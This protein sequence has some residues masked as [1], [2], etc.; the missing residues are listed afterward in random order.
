LL[1]SNRYQSPGSPVSSYHKLEQTNMNTLTDST[2]PVHFGVDVAKAE[3][4]LDLLGHT[5]RFTNDPKGIASLLKSVSKSAAHPYIVCEATGGY[6]RNLAKAALLQ[7]VL[8]SVVQPQRVREYANSQGQFAKSDP[9]DAA[10]LTQFGA[11]NKK[12]KPLTAKDSGRQKIDE[13]LRARSELIDA[14]Q[15]ESNRAEHRSGTVLEQVHKKLDAV[16]KE[17][18]RKLDKAIDAMVAGDE[19][20]S[21]AD[22]MLREVSGV[23]P[24]TSRTLL[25]F[26]PELGR[27][28]RGTIAALVGLA[29]FDKDSGKRT[30]KRYIRGGRSQIR[31]VLHMAAVS[32]TRSNDVLKKFYAELRS[33]GKEFKV[34]IVATARKLLIYLNSLMAKFLQN[35]VAE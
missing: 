19:N 34:A 9:L 8:I 33:N 20:L 28:G 4:V 22:A 14:R 11:V 10:L 30:G 27:V 12:L 15:R 1:S 31:K 26:L 5:R 21:K 18:I 13:L 25:A 3:L 32:A 7:G 17:Q 24:Q 29:P 23:G 16:Y 35:P 2:P 6:E